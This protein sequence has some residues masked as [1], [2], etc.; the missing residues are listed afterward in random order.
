MK[1]SDCEFLTQES[2]TLKGFHA[3]S[4]LC[5]DEL[6]TSET[7]GFPLD[8][9]FLQKQEANIEIIVGSHSSSPCYL[10]PTSS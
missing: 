4:T 3:H 8:D 6:C 10:S 2:A 1:I 5:C 7:G 9:F